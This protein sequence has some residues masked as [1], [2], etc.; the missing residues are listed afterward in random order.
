MQHVNRISDIRHIDDPECAIRIANAYFPNAWTDA[1][2]RL[3]VIRLPA[4]L[5]LVDL[6]S[7]S[8]PGA[9]RKP[10]QIVQGAT[11]EDGR[12]DALCEFTFYIRF[13]I[14]PQVHN[15]PHEDSPRN[16]ILS[17]F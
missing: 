7:G 10:P 14:V 17:G 4:T 12:L 11:P 16:A 8:A 6:V 13:C 9:D 1:P 2:H 3:P 15:A 5:H